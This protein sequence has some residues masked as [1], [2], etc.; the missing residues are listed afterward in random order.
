MLFRSLA[1]IDN[2]DISS[3]VKSS[4]L[5]VL[6]FT[7]TSA[8]NSRLVSS[9]RYVKDGHHWYSKSGAADDIISHLLDFSVSSWYTEMQTKGET[10]RYLNQVMA[11]P[12]D[13]DEHR[14]TNSF[15]GRNWK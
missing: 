9:T 7:P 2:V 14:Q 5:V 12:T 3:F 11:N 6:F 1:T 4:T 15:Q 13:L 10:I 8:V